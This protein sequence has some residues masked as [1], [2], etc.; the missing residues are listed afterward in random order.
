[1]SEYTPGPWRS[2]EDL[3]KPSTLFIG[4][5]G[6]GYIAEIHREDG[7]QP[8]DFRNAQI[9]QAA[10]DMLEGLL[11]AHTQLREYVDYHHARGGCSVD[12]EMACEAVEQA[13]K[14]AGVELPM[15][16]SINLDETEIELV[17]KGSG[18]LE[19]ERE[20][21]KRADDLYEWGVILPGEDEEQLKEMI[22]TM[23]IA[24]ALAPAAWE[25]TVFSG[26]LED[27]QLLRRKIAGVEE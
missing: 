21:G 9:I 16:N 4:K 11:L 19:A 17:E 2:E 14:K 8:E 25:N 10:P 15:N 13:I 24:Y 6:F 20:T 7:L 5:A 12:M 26:S 18:D 23:N 22:G 27:L 1:M 3:N